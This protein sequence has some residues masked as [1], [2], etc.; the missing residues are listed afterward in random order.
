MGTCNKYDDLMWLSFVKGEIDSAVAAEMESHCRS[1]EECRT[2]SG[3]LR[4]IESVKDFY[5]Q[6]PPSSWTSEAL[7]QFGSASQ[8]DQNSLYG[9]LV[10]DSC[11]HE[12]EAVRSQRLEMRRLVFDLPGFELDLAMEY[13]GPQLEMVMGHLLSKTAE[14]IEHVERLNVELSIDSRTYATKPNEL[15]EFI[16]RVGA[17]PSGEPM[18]IRCESEEGTC[19]IVLIPC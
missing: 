9:E 13:S 4:K 8:N 19:A 15:G 12:M 3:F 6:E 14:P 11:V 17:R 1:C 18:E 5:S 10:F 16:F 7:A 2:Q